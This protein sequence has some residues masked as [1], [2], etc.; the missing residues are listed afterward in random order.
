MGKRIPPKAQLFL[1]LLLN[2]MIA[3]TLSGQTP[4]APLIV[5]SNIKGCTIFLNSA[6]LDQVTP[7]F[8][9]DFAV[10]EHTLTVVAPYGK[11]QEGKVTV[12]ADKRNELHI[13][14][15]VGNL[16][17]TS[18]IPVD[19][20]YINNIPT[21]P[22]TPAAFHN[23]SEG[24][25]TLTTVEKYGQRLSRSISLPANETTRIAMNYALADLVIGCKQQIG[26]VYLNGQLTGQ[27]TPAIFT[28]LPEGLYQIII[29]SDAGQLTHNTLLKPGPDN[30]IELGYPP[31]DKKWHYI[32]GAATLITAGTVYF[33][34]KPDDKKERPGIPPF[35]LPKKQ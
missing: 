6:P 14:F 1:A 24:N 20:L 12:E 28:N 10:G 32:I 29:K 15:A 34:L 4:T 31:K 21:D 5:N 3:G 13:D 2:F 22:K 11:A 27:L 30:R 23:L 25:Y 35:E 9:T 16:E 8:F 33:A 17:I 7:A 19:S 26:K 18:N